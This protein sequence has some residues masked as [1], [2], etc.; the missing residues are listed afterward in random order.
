MA[1]ITVFCAHCGTTIERTPHR[2]KQN[3][4]CCVECR[5]K[6]QKV[7]L[8]DRVSVSCHWCGKVYTEKAGR[9]DRTKYCSTECKNKF[10]AKERDTRINATCQTCGKIF[11]GVHDRMYCSRQCAAAGNAVEKVKTTCPVCRSVFFTLPSRRRTYCGPAC[12]VSA[13]S[14]RK[15]RP[16]TSKTCAICGNNFSVSPSRTGSKYC[17]KCDGRKYE[18]TYAETRVKGESHRW[19]MGGKEKK[20]GLNWE[21]QSR[22]ARERDNHHCVVCGKSHYFF[23]RLPVHHI[24]PRREY[25][26]LHTL[27]TYGNRLSNLITLCPSCHRKAD[28]GALSPHYLRSLI[29]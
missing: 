22:E 5:V 29:K 10:L 7:N 14:G 12:S 8:T 20:Y 1:K 6:W 15:T 25:K 13:K 19:F 11:Y 4:F 9:A 27:E 28:Q 3:N 17:N 16:H 24:T 18:N 2:I 23:L 26:T 21:D